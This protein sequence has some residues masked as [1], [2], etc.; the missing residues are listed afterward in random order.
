MPFWLI[1]PTNSTWSGLRLRLSPALWS[2]WP[3]PRLQQR[4]L[5]LPKRRAILATA[6]SLSQ[7]HPGHLQRF[8]RITVSRL[9][10][11][12][13]RQVVHHKTVRSVVVLLRNVC[14]MIYRP[15]F[16]SMTVTPR[17]SRNSEMVSFSISFFFLPRSILH[18]THLM[19]LDLYYSFPWKIISSFT[20][21]EFR[22]NYYN[23]FITTFP[24]M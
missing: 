24:A 1:C 11:L 19:W 16:L 7:A 15:L 17:R 22:V 6:V 8:S 3:L 13:L 4:H 21:P 18:F 9:F 5:L 14:M 20:I 12:L 23:H 2:L 10:R